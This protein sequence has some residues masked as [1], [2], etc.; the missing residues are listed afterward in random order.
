M[1]PGMNG[2]RL[3]QLQRE[4]ADARTPEQRL[5]ALEALVA[6]SP[7]DAR[8]HYQYGRELSLSRSSDAKALEQFKMAL[9]ADPELAEARLG[10]GV[11]YHRAGHG[12]LA[13]RMY[14]A[15]AE[16]KPRLAKAWLNLGT[17]AYER[18][19][20]RAAQR[21]Y[22]RAV[23][24]QPKDAT[25]RH[26]LAR[27]LYALGKTDRAIHH[28]Q[29][30]LEVDPEHPSALRG[31][32]M[33]LRGTGDERARACHERAVEANPGSASLRGGLAVLLEEAGDTE[34]AEEVLRAGVAAA[35]DSPRLWEA[36]AGF[37]NRHER[38]EEA[39]AAL[40]EGLV[41][42]AGDQGIRFTL[43]RWLAR[44]ERLDEAWRE[45]RPIILA[46]PQ[47]AEARRLAAA[48]HAC[49]GRHQEAAG[50]ASAAMRLQP[51]CPWPRALLMAVSER[52]ERP[53][54]VPIHD[55][56]G[57]LPPHRG[58][59]AAVRGILQLALGNT[60]RAGEYLNRAVQVSPET[61]L[62]RV[63][64]ALVY[65]A[66]DR[67][68]LAY[69]ELRTA[70][71]LEPSNFH[72]QH[73]AGEAAFHIGRFAEASEAF[74]T[75]LSLEVDEP[76]LRALT[77]FCR[78]RAYRKV[79][80]S[81]EAVECYLAAQRLYP[82]HAPS[83]FG[84]GVALQEAGKPDEAV[85]HYQR[86]VDLCPQHA[87]ALMGVGSCLEVVGRA[88]EA[89]QAYRAALRADPQYPPPRYNLAV[90]LERTGDPEEVV[91]LLRGYLSRAP[92]SP[93]AADAKRRLALAQLRASGDI[94]R[95][96]PDRAEAGE[97]PFLDSSQDDALLDGEPAPLP[98][99]P[100]ARS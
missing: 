55:D 32:A 78:A 72:V 43:V 62:P 11:I 41:H 40:R 28:W 34:A 64:R 1:Y 14:A 6:A 54:S 57:V 38:A 39:V 76:F 33:A 91:A 30:A 87:R 74:R 69:D 83:F 63:A 20:L 52:P 13:E 19:D 37:L 79:G 73:L 90:L 8:A 27:A 25:A 86:C 80:Q 70:A 21:A 44:L 67:M 29:R 77:F 3:H 93:S 48:L 18:R 84:C 88:P 35:P 4:V 22:A 45:L 94:A 61:A 85:R 95:A 24:A 26:G 89:V 5:T 68:E 9:A 58:Y 56:R 65:M 51:A 36:L 97:T 2:S 15:A 31:L 10:M 60:D 47:N 16:G 7:G 42:T 46:D 81:R 96:A 53:M 59:S 98:V 75:A 71:I 99:D 82:E 66:E 92:G 23:K 49:E 17:L 100:R 12:D 50:A